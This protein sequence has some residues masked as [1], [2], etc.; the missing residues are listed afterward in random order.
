MR[1]RTRRI[2]TAAPLLLMAIMQ[3]SCNPGQSPSGSD[4]VV[5]TPGA[6]AA[7]E[8]TT[9]DGGR[10][11]ATVFNATGRFELSDPE[12]YIPSV[13]DGLPPYCAADVMA[14]PVPGSRIG[15]VVWLP[16]EN[17]NGRL[18]MVGNGG[19]S[20]AI[21][22]HSLAEGIRNGFAV[23]AT[24][25][26]HQGHD[27]AFARGNP[28]RI[29]DWAWRAVHESVRT[30]AALVAA[31]YGRGAE[32][33]Y[34]AGCSTGGHQALMSAQR[35]PADFD[36]IIAGAP[37][38][39]RTHLNAGFLWQFLKNHDS[40]PPYAP[41]L[42]ASKLELLHRA[43]LADCRASNGGHA[44]GLADDPWL[45]D[46]FSCDFDPRTLLC[47]SAEDKHCLTR[48]EVDAARSIY[49]GP[50]NPRT[51]ERIYF[52]QL[53]GTEIAGGPPNLPGWSLYWA[54]PA[55]P[56]TPARTGF[57]KYWAL[58]T[59]E[60]DWWS[61]DFDKDMQT[62]DER[63]AGTVNAM[64]PDLRDFRENGGKLLHYHGL[65]DAVVPASDSID[66]FER[67]RRSL[68]G[69]VSDFYRLFLAPGVHH[70]VGGP[71]ADRIGMLDALVAW[72]ERGAAP[73]RIVAS[74]ISERQDDTVVEF[75]RPL[76][77]YPQ[78]A[79]YEGAGDPN[80]ADSFSCRDADNRFDVPKLG[81]AYRR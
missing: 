22:Y 19:Y 5:V 20:S 60:W 25:T 29:V 32:Y 42:P 52:G 77:A 26:G 18:L 51:G 7:F 58:H 59:D 54:D 64:S 78:L 30:S 66:Y 2:A 6:C 9:Q 17:W 33:R 11:T 72:V 81:N 21:A 57:W 1:R 46:P 65:S 50:T 37:G 16:A 74:R 75:E 34:F 53:P 44:G 28:E 35:F 55:E 79:V 47:T 49:E 15:I 13:I 10:V 45:N 56:D 24:D 73:D 76:C 71:G 40:K 43:V 27:P 4:H 61:F 62:T 80:D 38:H 41:I 36:G 8:G 63:L 23:V 48:R 31:A 3:Q 67:V 69:D 70:C 68:D 14:S 39:N 12:P